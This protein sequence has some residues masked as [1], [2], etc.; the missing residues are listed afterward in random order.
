MGSVCYSS[1]TPLSLRWVKLYMLFLS[2][3]ATFLVEFYAAEFF[4]P[5]DKYQKYSGTGVLLIFKWPK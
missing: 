3:I 1:C 4:R 5:Y 2:G